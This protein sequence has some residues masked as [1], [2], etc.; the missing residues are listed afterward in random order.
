MSHGDRA[1]P[2]AAIATMKI[3]LFIASRIVVNSRWPW[4]RSAGRSGEAAAAW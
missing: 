4:N 1:A 2:K 3:A